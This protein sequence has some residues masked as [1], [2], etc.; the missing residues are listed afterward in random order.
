MEKHFLIEAIKTKLIYNP[1]TGDIFWKSSGKLAG[2][3]ENTGYRRISINYHKIL[4]HHIAYVLVFG[5]FPKNQ[6]DHKNKDRQDNSWQN[7]REA[8]AEENSWNRT[9]RGI[10]KFPETSNRQKKWMAEIVK[11]GT[12]YSNYFLTEEEALEWRA[13]M[14]KRLY[15]AFAKDSF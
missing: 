14:E 15:G 1:E 11:K 4:A 5:D 13:Q 10:Y 6:I 8:T 2:Y 12:R 7:L 3:I 9:T